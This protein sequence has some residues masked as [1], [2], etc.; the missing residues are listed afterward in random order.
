MSNVPGSTAWRRRLPV[1]FVAFVVVFACDTRVHSLK[2]F[3]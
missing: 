1:G 3:N 2:Q